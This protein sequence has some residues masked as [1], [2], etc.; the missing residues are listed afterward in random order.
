MIRSKEV[1][2]TGMMFVLIVLLGCMVDITEYKFNQKYSGKTQAVL[3]EVV[4][5]DYLWAP[6]HGGE[7]KERTR[8]KSRYI[9]EVN[10]EDY[11]FT[12]TSSIPVD[13][14]ELTILYN[15]SNPFDAQYNYN[16]VNKFES[17]NA[18]WRNLPYVFKTNIE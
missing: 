8:Y 15:P 4:S 14:S 17:E 7:V 6:Y 18:R 1:F 3:I 16:E 13:N 10:D 9:F 12:L 11:A 5:E 2:I